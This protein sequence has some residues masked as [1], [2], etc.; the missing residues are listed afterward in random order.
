MVSLRPI[1]MK[2]PAS[3][4]QAGRLQ[5]IGPSETLGP[6]VV[7]SLRPIAMKRPASVSQAG[8]LQEIGPSETLGPV[9]VEIRHKK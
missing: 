1:A 8:R 5:E 6:V 4:S 2:R 3:V 9:V 7:V